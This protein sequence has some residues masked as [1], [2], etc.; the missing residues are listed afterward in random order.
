MDVDN[1][2]R[3]FRYDHWANE[4]VLRSLK[5]AK[6]TPTR[7]LGL[8]AHVVGAEYIWH[9]RLRQE[10]SPL[11]VWSQLTV[12]DS[13]HH[14]LALKSLWESYLNS[15]GRD[16]LAASVSYKNTQGEAFTSGVSDILMHV[17]MHSAYHRGQIAAD[18]RANG[19]TPAYT[20][21][22]HA[23]RQHKVD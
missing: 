19:H 6:D 1:F 8:L 3:L 22:I 11:T 18:M 2:R 5:A 7:S 16:D 9:S 23:V 17:V 20:D 12:A 15:L 10:P 4:E 14:I 21:F 13:E